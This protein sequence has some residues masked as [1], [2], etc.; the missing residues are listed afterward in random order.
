[1]L[2]L[3]GRLPARALISCAVLL[4]FSTLS[5]TSILMY[6]QAHSVSTA[7]LHTVAGFTFMLAVGWHMKNNFPGLKHALRWRQGGRISWVLPT[8]SILVLAVIL[9]SVSQSQPL[10]SV[11]EWGNRIRAGQAGEVERLSYERI[12]LGGS[13]APVVLELD[14]RRG[15]FWRWPTYAF[16]LE[17]LEG[18]FIQALY[19]TH[20]IG[21]NDF[22]MQA[23]RLANGEFQFEEAPETKSER[24]RPESLPV[25]LHRLGRRSE[26]GRL[27]P[28]GDQVLADGVTGATM[29][30][31]FLAQI[32]GVASGHNKVR[33]MFEMNQSFDYNDYYSHDRFPDDPIYSGNGYSAQPSLVYG[34]EIDLSQSGQIRKLELLGHGHHSGRDGEIYKDVSRLTTALESVERLLVEVM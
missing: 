10:L 19:A 14:L 17:T 27:V 34:V 33:L 15:P 6:L 32:A 5:V 31:S 3:K 16:W 2:N 1:M 29:G 18:E 11:Y 9:G 23:T 13:E 25:F 21:K 20:K 30:T 4:L 12:T 8:V 7:L 26:T 24:E 28:A 22:F